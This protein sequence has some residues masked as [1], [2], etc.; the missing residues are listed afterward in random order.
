[1]SN[2]EKQGLILSGAQTQMTNTQTIWTWLGGMPYP[3]PDVKRGERY[4]SGQCWL[5]GGD[6][7]PHGWHQKSAFGPTFTDIAEVAAFESTACCQSCVALSK[8][9]AWAMYASANPDRG[10]ESHFPAVEGKKRRALNW[11][12]MSHL[13]TP[14]SHTVPSWKDWRHIVCNPPPPPFAAVFAVSQKQQI[15]FRA[16]INESAGPYWLQV[17]QQSVWVDP[18]KIGMLIDLFERGMKLG[19]NRAAMC[20]GNYTSQH[21]KGVSI[22][23]FISLEDELKRYRMATPEWMPICE[24]IAQK[25]E[26]IDEPVKQKPA[27][28][29]PQKGETLALQF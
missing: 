8:S 18:S 4:A 24:K 10:L 14:D 17:D 1:M 21:L 19:L 2:A 20:S 27:A 15:I 16:R 7:G 13:F 22:D 6:T 12:Y 5:C 9:D 28:I 23:A 3:P 25:P 26:V 11:L 29:P